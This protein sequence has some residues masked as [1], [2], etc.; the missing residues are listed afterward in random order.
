MRT[1]VQ[2]QG[3]YNQ[4]LGAHMP[5]K[6]RLWSLRKSAKT[7]INFNEEKITGNYM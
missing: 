7:R 5:S 3:S 2:V 4:N 1:N 6:P